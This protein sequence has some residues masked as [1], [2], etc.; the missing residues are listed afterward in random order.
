[1]ETCGKEESLWIGRQTKA[2]IV[3]GIAELVGLLQFFRVPKSNGEVAAQRNDAVGIVVVN[4]LSDVF[5]MGPDNR[6][7]VVVGQIED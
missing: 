6:T 4:Y 7:V 3:R 5:G 2:I 1:M